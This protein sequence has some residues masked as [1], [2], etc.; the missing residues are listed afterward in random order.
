[1]EPETGDPGAGD[2][3]TQQ[4]LVAAQ[5]VACKN[6]N[7]PDGALLRS[8][9]VSCLL[10]RLIRRTFCLGSWIPGKGIRG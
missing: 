2:G 10:H 1:M 9:T 3:A 4:R 8:W 6:N 7:A 5:Q